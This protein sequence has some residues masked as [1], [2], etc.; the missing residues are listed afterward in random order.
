MR[1]VIGVAVAVALASI[2]AESQGG[3]INW[4]IYALALG[5]VWVIHRAINCGYYS[6]KGRMDKCPNCGEEKWKKDPVCLPCWEKQQQQQ[7]DACPNCGE[8]KWKKDPICL[9]CWEKQQQQMDACPNCGEEKWKKD[10][11]CLPCWEKQQQQMA[12]EQENAR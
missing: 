3:G 2:A 11:I 10:P 12:E 8:E 9:P 6:A 1:Y 7:I 5:F 4:G